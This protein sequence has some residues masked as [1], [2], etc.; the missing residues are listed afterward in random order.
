MN[1]SPTIA[2]ND[3]LTGLPGEA[4]IRK[5]LSDRHDTRLSVESCLVEIA[6]PR[7]VRAGIL[8]QKMPLMDAE[9]TLYRLLSQ[10]AGNSYSRYNALLR[11]LSS[12]EHALD[13]RMARSM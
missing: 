9:R 1:P 7:L 13:H 10:S 5:G 3:L 2:G 8:Q 6:A 12:F 4:L 11:E